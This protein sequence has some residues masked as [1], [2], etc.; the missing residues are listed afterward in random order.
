MVAERR[1]AIEKVAQEMC[2]SSNDTISGKRIVEIVDSTGLDVVK[3]TAIEVR[4]TLHFYVSTAPPS[5]ISVLQSDLL[6]LLRNTSCWYL[7]TAR[8]RSEQ[9]LKVHSTGSGEFKTQ[10]LTQH[11]CF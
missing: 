9:A 2:A 11:P 4:L 8:L 7:T 3:A 10:L 1:T 6:S 5:E